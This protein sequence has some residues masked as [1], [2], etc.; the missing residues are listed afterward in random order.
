MKEPDSRE[1]TLAEQ[2]ADIADDC[3]FWESRKSD[4][5]DQYAMACAVCKPL[6]RQRECRRNREQKPAAC[7][8]LRQQF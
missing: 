7:A 5:P 1:P 6:S 3:E 4:E 8:G 2:I